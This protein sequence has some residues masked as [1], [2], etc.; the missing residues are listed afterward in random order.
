LQEGSRWAFHSP[1]KEALRLVVLA[2]IIAEAAEN[3]CK[4]VS[5]NARHL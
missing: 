4:H 5:K 3:V 1:A 2:I